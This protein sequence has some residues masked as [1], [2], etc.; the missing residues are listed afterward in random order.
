ALIT[1]LELDRPIL[2]GHS[3]GASV[4]LEYAARFAIGP[5]APAG[6]VLVDGGMIQ[7][8]TLPGVTWEEMR[9]RLTPPRLAG[10]P[11]EKFL[12]MLRRPRGSWQPGE[13]AIQII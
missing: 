11:L 2:V 8:N 10:M 5:R 6:I 3:W 12:N 4:A 7:M 9:E 1:S 13:A